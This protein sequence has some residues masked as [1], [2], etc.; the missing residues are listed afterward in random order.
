MYLTRGQT[1]IEIERPD[2]LRDQIK[3]LLNGKH[4]TCFH[5]QESL[6]DNQKE[7]LC[8]VFTD[9]GCSVIYHRYEPQWIAFDAS[10]HSE[11]SL[12]RFK[13]WVDHDLT[14]LP[15]NMKLTKRQTLEIIREFCISRQLTDSIYWIKEGSELAR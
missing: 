10:I 8:V 12:R 3:K 14:P 11:N 7:D 6:A 2:R 15:A 5:V 9:R 1:W 13:I 4:E